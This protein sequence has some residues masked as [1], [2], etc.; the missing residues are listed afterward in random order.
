MALSHP[1][2][3]ER[4]TIAVP[5]AGLEAFEAALTTCCLAVGFFLDE[6]N[7]TWVI[8][9]IREIGASEDDLA[10]AIALA[11]VIS[12][13]SPDIERELVA[14]GGWLART[15]QAFPE[16]AIGARFA[17]RG[18]HIATPRLPG[19]ITIT[20]DAG[21]AFG[22]GEHGSTRGCLRALERIA[23]A[24]NPLRILD[25]G[26]GSGVLGIAGAK[27]WGRRIR[28]TDID[29][30]AVRVAAANAAQNGVAPLFRASRADGWTSPVL[31]RHTPYDL[32]F[33]NIL[34]RPLAAMAHQLAANLAP[35]G[36]AI[37]AGLLETQSRWVLSAHRRHGLVLK[38]RV[39]EGAWT[40]LVLEKPARGG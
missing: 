15:L 28:A 7:N 10:V 1:E 12:G 22:T 35:S 30:R 37:L 24:R 27:I 25:L 20:L 33:A 5:E 40:T 3:V 29:A 4:I 9:G 26:T 23:K 13:I 14:A 38:A 21:L 32:V 8:E 19:R 36:I 34:A 31:A 11:E 17:I 2:Q 18:T 6:A 16:Q 39:R